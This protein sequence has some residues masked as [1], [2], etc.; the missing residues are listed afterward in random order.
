MIVNILSGGKIARIIVD[1]KQS[2]LTT[3]GGGDSNGQ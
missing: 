3:V 2:G 1:L